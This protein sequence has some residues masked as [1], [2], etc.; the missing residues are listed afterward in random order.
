MDVVESAKM[1]HALLLNE[2]R[3]RLSQMRSFPPALWPSISGN[4][5][6][7]FQHDARDFQYFGKRKERKMSE[8]DAIYTL[9]RQRAALELFGG[10][11]GSRVI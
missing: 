5:P 3:W 8:H 2:G 10:R 4:G 7:L 11:Q 1:D 9:M 6:K